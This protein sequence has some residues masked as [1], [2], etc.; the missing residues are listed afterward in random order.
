MSNSN[1][2]EDRSPLRDASPSPSQSNDPAIS[3]IQSNDPAISSSQSDDPLT[4]VTSDRDD[5]DI[6]LEV[7]NELDIVDDTEHTVTHSEY[8]IIGWAELS[9][10][11]REVL[12]LHH[13]WNDQVRS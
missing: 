5:S 13:L 3:H 12:S 6:E 10:G 11:L 2:E 7:V 4:T 1:N 8:D 9:N